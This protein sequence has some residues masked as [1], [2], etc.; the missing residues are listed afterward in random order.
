MNRTA[1]YRPDDAKLFKIDPVSRYVM[2]QEELDRESID[3]HE[4]RVIATNNRDGPQNPDD[5]SYLT[6]QVSVMS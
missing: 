5:N 3:Y 4:F 6:V 1:L 2:L